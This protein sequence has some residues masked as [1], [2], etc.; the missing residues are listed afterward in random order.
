MHHLHTPQGLGA[1]FLGILLA[2]LLAPFVIRFAGP[3]G[4]V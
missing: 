1:A 4:L 3:K 2:L